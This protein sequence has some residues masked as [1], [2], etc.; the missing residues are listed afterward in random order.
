MESYQQAQSIDNGNQTARAGLGRLQSG[1]I[2]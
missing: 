2:L 1:K